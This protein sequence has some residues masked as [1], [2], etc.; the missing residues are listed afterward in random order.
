MIGTSTLRQVDLELF[1]A[2]R[3]IYE[4][5]PVGCCLHIVLDDQNVADQHLEHC[6]AYA[7]KNEHADCEAIGRTLLNDYTMLER[8]AIANLHS[9][10]YGSLIPDGFTHSEDL[11]DA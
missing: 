2:I 8:W 7:Q 5:N 6:I 11:G 1:T 9:A 10:I 3:L 4:R